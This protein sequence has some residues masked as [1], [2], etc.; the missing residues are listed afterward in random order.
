[1]SS[2]RNI[3][4]INLSDEGYEVCRNRSFKIEVEDEVFKIRA[5]VSE[6]RNER[7]EIIMMTLHDSKYDDELPLFCVWLYGGGFA[8]CYK[9]EPP[10]CGCGKWLV[11]CEDCGGLVCPVCEM[12]HEE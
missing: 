7:S 10:I 4:M 8:T 2:K 11:V 9:E 5:V 12:S 3:Q 6:I 1:M